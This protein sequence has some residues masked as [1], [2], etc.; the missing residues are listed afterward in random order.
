MKITFDPV[1]AEDLERQ[2]DYLISLKALGAAIRLEARVTAFLEQFLATHPR[3]GK[4]VAE[5][6]IWE[7]WVP[8]TRLVIWYRF[9]TTEIQV[10][11]IWHSAQ[12]REL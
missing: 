8:G 10:L 11:R 9:T 1:A 5:A 3:S 2:L 6:S 7:T 4:H 12:N